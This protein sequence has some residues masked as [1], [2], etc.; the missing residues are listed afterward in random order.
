MP[1]VRE[2]EDAPVNEQKHTSVDAA[3]G[4]T[5]AVSSSRWKKVSVGLK[6][7]SS[8]SV[9]KKK[10][11]ENGNGSELAKKDDGVH[12]GLAD[13]DLGKYIQNIC[14]VY[15]YIDTRPQRLETS[16]ASRSMVLMPESTA[17]TFWSVMVLSLVLFYAIAVPVRVAWEPK[18][19][20]AAKIFDTTSDVIFLVDIV[21]NFRT[22]YKKKGVLVMDPKQIAWK[23]FSSWFFIDFSA[24]IP[25]GWFTP[26]GNGASKAN[27]LFRLLRI[28]KLARIFRI[29]RYFYQ[30]EQ[31][32]R[33]NP[34]IVRF[35]KGAGGLFFVWHLVG[36]S[37]WYIVHS[38]IYEG[39]ELCQTEEF[40]LVT[41][42]MEILPSRCFANACAWTGTCL[43]EYNN[44][45]FFHS[46]PSEYHLPDNWVP[47]PNMATI[48]LNNQYWFAYFW[49]VQV[50]TGFGDDVEPKTI[51][52]VVFT[53]LITVWGLTL[54]AIIIGAASS[55]LS[56]IDS[57]KSQHKE[58]L[59]HVS[60]NLRHWKVPLF[61]QKIV[62]DF[63]E[64][65]WSS[66]NDSTKVLRDLPDTLRMRLRIVIYQDLVN[67]VPLFK[68]LGTSQ[69]IEVLQ[70][71]S[72]RTYL[73]GEYIVMEGE[74][75]NEMFFYRKGTD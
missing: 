45:D 59:D 14:N 17:M 21:I 24:S 46:I 22:A 62:K 38:S 65:T 51:L 55:A 73:P 8:N 41:N 26:E 63:Y 6:R 43:D 68:A 70:A 71:L 72:F 36:C 40:N 44:D 56:N 66:P 58:R 54:L 28:L 2:K 18:L 47:N 49:A 23:Y 9:G 50:T 42:E 29:G 74:I 12:D 16:A 48:S 67:K 34:S 20:P 52:E 75:G 53:I 61:F 37:Y 11:S 64:H 3:K 19:P 25:I 31:L 60:D 32:F 30:F 69:F 4:G 27:K 10:L 39:Y 13:E 5:V 1:S 15:K 57:V 7:L 35:M 33:L